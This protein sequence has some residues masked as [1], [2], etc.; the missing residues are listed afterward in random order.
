M[1]VKDILIGEPYCI[2]LS[3]NAISNAVRAKVEHAIDQSYY[4]A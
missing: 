2:V 3:F 1:S 4:V